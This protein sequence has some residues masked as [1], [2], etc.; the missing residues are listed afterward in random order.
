MRIAIGGFH[1][2][3][4]TFSLEPATFDRFVLADGWPGIVRGDEMFSALKG[5]NMA[6][7]GM[8]EACHEQG[9]EIVPLSWCN[10]SPCGRVTSDAFEKISDILL[11]D[12]DRAGPI[13]GLLLDLHGAMVTEQYED[14]EGEF[15]RR[16]R[17]ITGPDLPIVVSLD[18]HANLTEDMVHLADQLLIYRTYPHIDM[19]ETGRKAAFQIARH[20]ER[21]R[22][23]HKSFRRLP[24][25]V[26]N[27]VGCTMIGPSKE[28]F[29]F[30]AAMERLPD[31]EHVSMAFGFNPSDVQHCGPSIIAYGANQNAA[32][33]IADCLYTYMVER[34]DQFVADLWAVDE[35]V[36]HAISAAPGLN[37]PII[38]AD[39]QDNA[40]GGTSS[41]T[42][43]ILDSLVRHGVADA[44]IGVFCDPAAAAA[45]HEAGI[46]RD[47]S[48]GLGGKSGLPG[49]EP[50]EACYRVEAV[51]D[52][53]FLCNGGY[54]KG[55][56]MEL[57]PMAV[58]RLG[59]VRIV[60]STNPEQAADQAMFTHLGIDPARHAIVVLKSSVHYRAEF[61]PISAQ[62]IEVIA[63]AQNV[64]DNRLLDYRNLRKGL[65]IMP[66]G[67]AFEPLLP[68]CD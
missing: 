16:V 22:P 36:Q 60:V 17:A 7:A 24:F 25:L 18:F 35:A 14:G 15:L 44:V 3:T 55:S 8:I 23:C 32:D 33:R 53:R 40:G 52:G 31:I 6:A 57:G 29:E 56:Q 43:W 46:G 30:L 10:A 28:A 63:P 47:I 21:A 41:D 12:L 1:H 62:I 11:D 2:E 51:S 42:T 34:E 54:F 49:H 58:L 48:I 27:T 67:P 4:N 66:G 20:I 45:A 13:D 38:L 26:P 19:A 5:Y 59:G 50:F 65:R 64:A 37:R 68:L 39:V 61:Q 9:R